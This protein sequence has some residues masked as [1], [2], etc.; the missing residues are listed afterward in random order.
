M[1]N[2]TNW[3]EVLEKIL[4]GTITELELPEKPEDSYFGNI[5]IPIMNGL[6]E[7]EKLTI[8]T[9]PSY[10][11]YPD[12]ICIPSYF[13]KDNKSIETVIIDDGVYSIGNEAFNG[14]ENMKNLVFKSAQPPQATDTTTF[15]GLPTTCTIYV[16][17]GSLS[18]YTSATN[19]PST[20]SG[21]TY[22]EYS[23]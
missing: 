16:P 9:F 2:E 21:Y 6:P 13:M 12:T 4:C 1:A 18:E 11:Q 23:E 3:K 22:V 7:L 5:S 8:K 10:E 14:C 19:Y 17:E 20:S 15:Y